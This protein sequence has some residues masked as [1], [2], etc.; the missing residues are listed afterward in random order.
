ML[1]DCANSGSVSL[2]CRYVYERL[3][4][5]GRKPTFMTLLSTQL[6]SGIWH[7][8]YPGYIMF[9]AGSAVLFAHSTVVY[10]WEKSLPRWLAKSP[11]WWAFKVIATKT[12]LDFLAT[13]FL[14]LTW[15][16]VIDVWASVHYI[17]LIYMTSVLVL[18][19]VIPVKGHKDKAGK[20]PVLNSA[21]PVGVDEAV[22]EGIKDAFS[23]VQP[24]GVKQD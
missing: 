9:F 7:G 21:D 15:N 1:P 6:V 11:V 10:H 16:E 3:T 18:G 22:A 13:A 14:V 17:P 5:P 2:D 4:P 24:N 19:H 23:E 8:L 20:K 12:G